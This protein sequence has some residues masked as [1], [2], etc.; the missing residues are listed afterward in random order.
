LVVGLTAL[1]GSMIYE[2]ASPDELAREIGRNTRLAR[3]ARGLRQEDLAK[4]SNASLQAIKNLEGGGKVEL[5]TF[6]RVARALGMTA[7]ILAA[8]QPKP[9]SLDEIERIEAARNDAARVRTRI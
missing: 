4:L 1:G 8:C 5:V 6:L 9:R 7:G 3:A 2:L